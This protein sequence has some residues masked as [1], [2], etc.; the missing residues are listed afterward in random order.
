MACLLHYSKRCL[1]NLLCK[2]DAK[3]NGLAKATT[4]LATAMSQFGSTMFQDKM[5]QGLQACSSIPY[6]DISPRHQCHKQML[7][8]CTSAAFINCTSTFLKHPQT[9]SF[10]NF[11]ESYRVDMCK[12]CGLRSGPQS[13]AWTVRTTTGK[14]S[15]T[16]ALLWS[17]FPRKSSNSAIAR[18]HAAFAPQ[19]EIAVPYVTM[20]GWTASTCK[21]RTHSTWMHLRTH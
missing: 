5:A 14:P 4:S 13:S 12:H 21:T 16:T 6:P 3:H 15:R 1:Q 2:T 8:L 17:C 11:T 7:L 18:G 10:V 9:I 20:L 19:A